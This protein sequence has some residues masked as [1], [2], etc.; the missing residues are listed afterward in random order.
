MSKRAIAIA[1]LAVG[2]LFMLTR[3]LTPKTDAC[4]DRVGA[5]VDAQFAV[6]DRLNAPSSA[7]FPNIASSSV[8]VSKTGACAFSIQAYVE[9][10]NA[11]GVKLRRPW[12][13]TAISTPG[14]DRWTISDLRIG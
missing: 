13:A 2:A 8:S 6:R 5:Y 9:A 7:D 12:S 14:Q 10:Q 1:I 4:E 3:G 11:F